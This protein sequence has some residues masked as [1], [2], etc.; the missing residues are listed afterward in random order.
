MKENIGS[1]TEFLVLGLPA[2]LIAVILAVSVSGDAQAGWLQ[3]AAGTYDYLQA[4]NWTDKMSS[5]T[6]S[7]P[8]SRWRALR[9]RRS[10]PN[11]P[12]RA[13]WSSATEATS[14]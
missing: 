6:C 12:R 5:T 9:R 10:A 13:E 8:L 7:H 2:L 1:S 14:R 11:T 4:T 3:T